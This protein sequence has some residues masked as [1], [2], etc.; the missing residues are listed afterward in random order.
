M[1][2]EGTGPDFIEAL[3]RGLEVIAAFRPGRPAM[4]LDRGRRVDRAGPADRP[5]DPADARGARLRPGRRRHVRADPAG[6]GARRG[7]RPVAGPVGGRPP[8]H[9]AARS[10]PRP[11]RARSPS[12]TGRT[13]STSPAWPC[14]RSSGCR[15]R[16]APGSRRCRRRSGKVL[17]AALPD[18][19]VDARARRAHRAPGSRPGGSP[20][21]AERDA[22][23]REVQGPRLGADRRAARPRASGRS[24]HHCAT[25]RA[26]WSRRSTSTRTRPRRRSS[27]SSAS[28][29]RCLLPAAGEISADFARLD[30]RPA[31]HRRRGDR[32]RRLWQ[33]L[34]QRCGQ[35]SDEDGSRGRTTSA[36]R[37]PATPV[38]AAR[39]RLLPG[40]RRPVR[41]DAARRP[42]RRRRQ[43]RVARRR[44]DPHLDPA[45]AAATSRPTTWA[46]TA[47]SARSRWTCAT[48]P[49]SS[50]P[51]SSPAGPT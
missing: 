1:P 30:D 42:G 46:S 43:G 36:G 5:P 13:S 19:E 12:S 49:T 21:R 7:L 20:D 32:R 41:D 3:A 23:L 26:G 48:T 35:M 15:C 25:G 45:R 34:R 39:R 40:A 31:R 10:A 24:P 14:R 18:D 8:A 50:W 11:S 51:A 38:G 9:G 29:C 2:R 37:R 22:A 4:T 47:A 17:L 16:S 28:T 6:A 44:R 33:D 27:G